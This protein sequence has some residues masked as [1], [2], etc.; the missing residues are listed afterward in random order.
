VEEKKRKRRKIDRPVHQ[1]PPDQGHPAQEGHPNGEPKGGR[2][3]C[4]REEH[5]RQQKEHPPV[6]VVVRT[7]YI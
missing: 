5:V 6:R 3:Q 1:I 2:V 4:D 7:R